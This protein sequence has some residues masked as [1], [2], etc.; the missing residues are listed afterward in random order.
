[1][2]DLFA[3]EHKTLCGGTA[4]HIIVSIKLPMTLTAFAA[5]FLAGLLFPPVK[6]F[7]AINAAP[8]AIM[9]AAALLITPVVCLVTSDHSF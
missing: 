5:A 8:P 1:M 4:Y 7:T 3:I 9:P 2:S 6:V